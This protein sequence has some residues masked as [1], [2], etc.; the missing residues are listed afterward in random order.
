MLY[1][2][3]R[4][5]LWLINKPEYLAQQPKSPQKYRITVN[6]AGYDPKLI[7]TE[8]KSCKLIVSGREEHKVSGD[9]YSIKD[10]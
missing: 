3:A 8:V 9:D 7:K 6:C 4:K 2:I 1:L 10:L 5:F